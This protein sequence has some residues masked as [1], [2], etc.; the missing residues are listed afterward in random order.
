MGRYA[1]DTGGGDFTPAP[2]GTHVARCIQLIDIGTHHGE[3]QGAPTK[4]NQVIVR[5]EL[6][7][8]TVDTE[9]GPQPMLVS[10]FYTNSLGEKANLRKDLEAWRGRQFTVEEL[11]KFDLESILDKPCLVTI[12]HNEKKK[13]VVKTVSGLVKGMTCPPA[14][15]QT[16][17][18][19]IDDWDDSKFEALPEGF[20]KLIQESDEYKE[21][22][23][24]PDKASN[25]S[26]KHV[27]P[28]DDD[29]PF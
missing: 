2:E 26:A 10:K 24:P 15:N 11:M 7:N 21:S 12:A 3:Y 9:K 1:S 22:L 19:W 28:L 17:T 8:E 18:F 29:I 4:R 14:H 25:G 6:P 16:S 5:W 20:K 27:D 13:A 23:A